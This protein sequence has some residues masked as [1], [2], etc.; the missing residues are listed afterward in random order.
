MT[1]SQFH[2]LRLLLTL[3]ILPW[4]V[5]SYPS[6]P[7]TCDIETMSVLGHGP[8]KSTC[9]DCYQVHVF[10]KEIVDLTPITISITGPEPYQGLLLQVKNENNQTIG[11][12]I[13]F[14]ESLFGP[15][16]CDD[17]DG[18]Y[19]DDEIVAVLGQMDPRLKSW[20][21]T[22]KWRFRP[23]NALLSSSMLRVQGMVVLDYENFHILPETAF[24]LKLHGKSMFPSTSIPASTIELPP[25]PSSQA[26]SVP[27]QV[28]QPMPHVEPSPWVPTHEEA[29]SH[30]LFMKVLI[31][32]L[33]MYFIM[34]LLH[35]YWQKRKRHNSE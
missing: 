18:S 16:S 10:P 12:F 24:H 7:G 32:I 31:V 6:T 5:V 30:S 9:A 29:S 27:S 26:I 14:D 13:D 1:F 25:L 17:D 2:G 33:S 11:E 35:R 21:T 15:V 3:L 4:S 19:S 23:S 22:A 34:A 28:A 8:S 20:P